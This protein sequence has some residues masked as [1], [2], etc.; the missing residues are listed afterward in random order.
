MSDI[1]YLVK[2]TCPKGHDFYCAGLLPP[3]YY[4]C[5]VCNAEKRNKRR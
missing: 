1:G 3:D 4:A 2:Y 5:P